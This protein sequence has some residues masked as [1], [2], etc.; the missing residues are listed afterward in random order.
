MRFSFLFVLFVLL[1]HNT[2]AFQA[3]V[4]PFSWDK[5]E[6]EFLVRNF[7]TQDGLPVNAINRIIPHPNGY[8]YITTFDGLL[9]FDGNRFVSYTTT[10]TPE[11]KSNRLDFSLLDGENGLWIIDV[12]GNLYLFR[13]GHIESFHDNITEKEVTV[14]HNVVDGSGNLWVS[15]NVGLYHHQQA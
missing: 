2:L 8:L 12:L 3:R 1:S 10:D 14:Y 9:Q 11:L 4:V 13:D 7:T 5:I 15:T 6:D